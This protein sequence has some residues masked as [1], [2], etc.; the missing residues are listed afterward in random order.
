MHSNNFHFT[1]N[2]AQI[3]TAMKK[4]SM[5]ICFIGKRNFGQFVSQYLTEAPA[6]GNFV[7]VDTGKIVGYLEQI[8]NTLFVGRGLAAAMM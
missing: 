8:P 1:F 2:R 4:E 7:D 3:P 5:G 6:P